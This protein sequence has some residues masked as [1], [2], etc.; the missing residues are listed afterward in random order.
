M[1]QQ[2]RSEQRAT[3]FEHTELWAQ[4]TEPDLVA[5]ELRRLS[6]HLEFVQQHRFG[7]GVA[8]VF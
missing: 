2:R 8:M 1:S 4:S 6:E 7:E 3:R 5:A